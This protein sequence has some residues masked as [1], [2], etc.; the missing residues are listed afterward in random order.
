MSSE[1]KVNEIFT[2]ICGEGV[3]IGQTMT[4][5]RLSGCNLVCLG[6]DTAHEDGFEMSVDSILERVA[7]DDKV[8]RVM[9]TGGEPLLQD[10]TPL[11]RELDS[12]GKYTHI[13][14][15][16]TCRPPVFSWLPW[17]ACSPKPCSMLKNL[18]ALLY[19]D[20]VKLSS[21]AFYAFCD[22]Q[23]KPMWESRRARQVLW[24]QPWMKKQFPDYDKS[25]EALE[26]CRK[27]P[28]W[29]YSTQLHKTLHLR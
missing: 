2:S 25:I 4:F 20:E 7:A 29:R 13:E 11:I 17:L 3:W 22:R 14:T 10:V 26:L 8:D 5:I 16:G 18:P 27:F 28:Q 12:M 21:K 24:I 1:L 23:G 6:C 9:I 19:A 15:N